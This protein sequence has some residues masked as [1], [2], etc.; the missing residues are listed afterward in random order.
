MWGERLI[1]N[2]RYHAYLVYLNHLYLL[3]EQ[4]IIAEMPC[5]SSG[6]DSL[7]ICYFEVLKPDQLPQW[8]WLRII[9][10]DGIIRL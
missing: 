10:R 1:N 5:E 7:P 6:L 3:Q 8:G 4:G 9:N 2:T